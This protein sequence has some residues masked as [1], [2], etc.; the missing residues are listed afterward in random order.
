MCGRGTLSNDSGIPFG[1]LQP[2]HSSRD[3]AEM[4]AQLDALNQKVAAI[5][6]LLTNHLIPR[7]VALQNEN[8]ALKAA[9]VTAA[10]AS[11]A[12]IAAV[13]TAL[14]AGV[15]TPLANLVSTL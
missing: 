10:G 12:D 4:T 14:D 8:A 7:V 9:Q 6:D 13:S 5:V 15:Q 2:F 3:Y 11:D 1:F